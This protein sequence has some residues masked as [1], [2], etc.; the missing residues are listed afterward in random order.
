MTRLN[1]RVNGFHEG[2]RVYN[3]DIREL[4]DL[5]DERFDLCIVDPF[6]GVDPREFIDA[7][8]R[9]AENTLLIR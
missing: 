2:F 3:R 5:I 7:A 9:L 6:P 4:P 8:K 1:L